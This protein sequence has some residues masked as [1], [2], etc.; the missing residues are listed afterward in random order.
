MHPTPEQLLVLVMCAFTL[1]I[2]TFD[3]MLSRAIL[4]ELRRNGQRRGSGMKVPHDERARRLGER[5][6]DA[7][8]R[9]WSMSV[10]PRARFV[11]PEDDDGC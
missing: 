4:R 8:G 6:D 9:P 5:L 1:A 11:K 2:V 3:V 7:V 10:Q